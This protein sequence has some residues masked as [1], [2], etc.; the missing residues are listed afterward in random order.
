VRYVL[1][2]GRR[3]RLYFTKSSFNVPN[4]GDKKLSC[5]AKNANS[6]PFPRRCSSSEQRNSSFSLP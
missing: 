2:T 3:D 4:F 1:Y 5:S 6:L